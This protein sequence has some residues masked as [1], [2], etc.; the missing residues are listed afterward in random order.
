M[1]PGGQD[2]DEIAG[3]LGVNAHGEVVDDQQAHVLNLVE[4]LLAT[5]AATAGDEQP[6][7]QLVHPGIRVSPVRLDWVRLTTPRGSTMS[8]MSLPEQLRT[9]LLGCTIC[10]PILVFV[11]FAPM[12]LLG[13][14][15]VV[16]LHLLW[17]KVDIY[18]L[19]IVIAVVA[20]GTRSGFDDLMPEPAWYVLMFSP[21]VLMVLGAMGS[22]QPAMP[23]RGRRV[24]WAMMVLLLAALVSMLASSA[25]GW[26]TVTSDAYMQFALLALVLVFLTVMLAKRWRSEGPI[27]NDVASLFLALVLLNGSGVAAWIAG[28]DWAVDPD[29]GRFTGVFFNANYAGMTSM[30]G[31][32]LLLFLMRTRPKPS[33]AIWYLGGAIV[34]IVSLLLSGS[35]GSLLGLGAGL[36]LWVISRAGL[37]YLVPAI[38]FVV[39]GGLLVWWASPAILSQAEAAFSRGLQGS[40]LSSGRFAIYEYLLGVWRAS[41]WFGIGYRSTEQLGILDGVEAHNI[42]LSTLVETGLVGFVPFLVLIICILA[43]GRAN[44]Q[45][46]LFVPVFAILVVEMTESSLFG[47]GGPTALAFWLLF[48]LHAANGTARTAR[49]PEPEEFTDESAGDMRRTAPLSKRSAQRADQGKSGRQPATSRPSRHSQPQLSSH[50]GSP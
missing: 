7:G 38:P 5:D 18:R 13:L 25:A 17:F 26:Q 20:A 35:R 16:V 43:A 48:A 23:R 33:S 34:L 39:L 9:A 1:F 31:L 3:P 45:P 2:R 21:L 36:A 22:S 14:V 47:F 46:T 29:Y 27:R 4:H 50:V 12:A 37:K 19:A 6:A 8:R 15:G 11:L 42:Y 41:P 24:S 49:T 10:L 30:L 40:D 44:G 32:A 28:I